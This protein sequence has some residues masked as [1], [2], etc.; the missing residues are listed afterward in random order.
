MARREKEVIT[1]LCSAL[2]RP[3]LKYHNQVWG[4]QHVRDIE[5]LGRVQRR[6]QG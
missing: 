4:H 5:L 1:F 6:P 2:M 3:N